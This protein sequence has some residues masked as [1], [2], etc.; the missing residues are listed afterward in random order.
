MFRFGDGINV[1]VITHNG[2]TIQIF[3]FVDG[4]FQPNEYVDGVLGFNR[5]DTHCSP[6]CHTTF[7]REFVDNSMLPLEHDVFSLCLAGP[8]PSLDLGGY[9]VEHFLDMNS[10]GEKNERDIHWLPI[11]DPDSQL[12]G[13]WTSTAGPSM[14]RVG[15]HS[16]DLTSAELQTHSIKLDSGTT[17]LKLPADVFGAFYTVFNT[18]YAAM[19]RHSETPIMAFNFTQTLHGCAGPIR[20]DYIP[21]DEMPTIW[22]TMTDSDGMS[23]SVAIDAEHWA[24]KTAQVDGLPELNRGE[25][26]ICMAVTVSTTNDIVLGNVFLKEYYSIFDRENLRIGVAVADDCGEFT[27]TCSRSPTEC[28]QVPSPPPRPSDGGGTSP[29]VPDACASLPCQNGGVCTGNFHYTYFGHEHDIFL[30]DCTD[31]GYGGADCS[32][33]ITNC[34][35]DH[36]C[37]DPTGS[38]DGNTC[39]DYT[40]L[41]AMGVA[42][43]HGCR[44]QD[45]LTGVHDVNLMGMVAG[46]TD[47]LVDVN[48]CS[49][50]PCINGAVCSD[51]TSDA[52]VPM[53]AFVCECTFPYTGVGCGSPNVLTPDPMADMSC[54]DYFF[55]TE[56]QT[57]LTAACCADDLN[58]ARG[59]PTVCSEV[60]EHTQLDHPRQARPHTYF[61]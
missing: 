35:T 25:T 20:E 28:T 8:V 13:E 21:D 27:P 40:A 22:I 9:R 57:Q 12:Q 31:T 6:A 46:T 24:I 37:A 19:D 5:A 51:S 1:P 47:C 39:S 36:P 16:L 60:R 14:I 54:Q 3:D 61:Q 41:M 11:D 56:Y 2:A 33:S 55:A 32:G 49:S 42:Y 50:T 15:A 44:C 18:H 59:Y 23:F 58:C 53:N 52:T 7:W 17:K 34:D 26:Y 45:G 4:E 29:A 10:D 43:N 48:E 38:S 30:C